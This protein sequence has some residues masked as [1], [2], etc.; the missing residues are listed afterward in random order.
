[1]SDYPPPPMPASAEK[2]GPLRRLGARIIDGL[3][4]LIPVIVVSAIFG[5]VSVGGEFDGGAFLGAVVGV[6][7][8]FAYFVLME[9]SRG[10]TVG[11]KAL[12]MSVHDANGG[13]I[14]T[15][16]S[17]KRNAYMFL[18]VVP[19]VGGLL[20]FAAAIGIAITVSG[21]P[22]GRGFHDKFGDALVRRNP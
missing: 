7:I 6:A 12:G 1:M 18:G 21:D 14:T 8:S 4:M 9:T 13:P 17:A 5:G 2:A 19:V 20:S 10:G 16:Q 15:E 22:Q 3:V 11:K